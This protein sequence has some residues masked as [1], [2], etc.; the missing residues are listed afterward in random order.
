MTTTRRIAGVTTALALALSLAACGKD[1]APVKTAALPAT[2]ATTATA[3]ASTAA[4][5]APGAATKELGLVKP[6]RARVDALTDALRKGDV[7]GSRQAYEAYDAGWNG[8]EVYINVRSRALYGDLETDLQ[9][10]I[11]D[12]LKPAQ[13]DLAA[14]VPLSE[15]LGRKFDD[16]LVLIQAGPPLSPLF[17]DLAALRIVRA[18]LRIATAA[19]ATAD[20]GK[21]R[22]AFAAFKMGFPSVAGLVRARSTSAE[23]EVS[24]ALSDA[25]ARFARAG[26]A[27]DDLKPLVA[28]LTARYNF[29]VSLWNAPARNADPAK[30]S[31]TD[32]DT[33]SLAVLGEVAVKL[34]AARA[35]WSS[36]NFQGATDA[37]ASAGVAFER[38]RPAL[39]TKSAEAALKTALDAFTGAAV[40]SGDAAKVATTAR[41]AQD[42]VAVAQQVLV[43]QFWTDSRLQQFLASLPKS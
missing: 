12:G 37:N 18:D 15:Q 36:G 33:K 40:A 17:D 16:A 35:A 4:S 34:R 30:S 27:A 11:A 21:A 9:A 5:L 2:G 13:P 31:F 29:V 38:V 1:D 3:P 6:V 32:D 39:A 10:K 7:A 26:A 43:G 41:A 19:L 42:A 14:L 24:T 28:M 23:A 22:S 25:D 20:V 8:I